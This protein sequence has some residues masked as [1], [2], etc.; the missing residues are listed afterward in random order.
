MLLEWRRVVE[1]VPESGPA[2]DAFWTEKSNKWFTLFPTTWPYTVRG[3]EQ[4]ADNVSYI[5]KDRRRRSERGW[6]GANQNS[7]MEL[8]LYLKINPKHFSSNSVKTL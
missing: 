3:C 1:S 5:L 8:G 2:A 7:P 6:M 4:I